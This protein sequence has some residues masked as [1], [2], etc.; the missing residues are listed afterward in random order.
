MQIIEGN[1]QLCSDY[2]P[3]GNASI[4]S[5]HELLSECRP[6]SQFG[7]PLCKPISDLVMPLDNSAACLARAS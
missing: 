4:P 7:D 3:P 2:L 6:A 5:G 1:V